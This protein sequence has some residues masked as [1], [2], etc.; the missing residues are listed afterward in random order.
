MSA[1]NPALIRFQ[2]GT[3]N[4]CLPQTLQTTEMGPRSFGSAFREESVRIGRG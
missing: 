2:Q 3:Q 1:E 4:R